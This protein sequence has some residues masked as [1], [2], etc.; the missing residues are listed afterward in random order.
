MSEL[1]SPGQ[2]KVI[3]INKGLKKKYTYIYIMK[4]PY[5]ERG[6]EEKWK[7]CSR[8]NDE[9]TVILIIIVLFRRKTMEFV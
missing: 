6:E 1:R 8:T 7:T 2:D 9:K 3:S 4:N 5:I